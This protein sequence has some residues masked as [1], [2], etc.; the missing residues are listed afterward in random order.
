MFVNISKVPH[1]TQDLE[2]AI[3]KEAQ[4]APFKMSPESHDASIK[5][6]GA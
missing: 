3:L 1:F 6:D 2:D 5:F 4:H